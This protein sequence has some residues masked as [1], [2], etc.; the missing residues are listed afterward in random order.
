MRP[1]NLSGARFLLTGPAGGLN[2]YT[3]LKK[4]LAKLIGSQKRRKRARGSR[5]SPS[6][7]SKKRA[8]RK[9]LSGEKRSS[10]R[11]QG[12]AKRQLKRPKR[13]QAPSPKQG[14]PPGAG[15]QIGKVIAF[16]RIPVVAVLKITK[17][18]LKVGERIWIKGHTTDVKQTVTSMQINHQPVQEIGKGDEAGV[19]VS[20][21]ARRGDRVYRLP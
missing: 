7:R 11:A 18:R 13:K 1:R 9:K 2:F 12:G 21:R 4:L 6:S 8:A 3:M 19:K 5:K 17:G 10:V 16:F 15:E 14:P 20:S